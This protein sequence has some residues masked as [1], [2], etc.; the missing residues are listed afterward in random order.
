MSVLTTIEADLGKVGHAF[1]TGASKLK[2]VIIATAGVVDKNESEIATIEG[3]AN[4]VVAQIYPGAELVAIAIE[5]TM[6]K[7]F[8]AIDKAAAAAGADGMNVQLDSA[9]VAA[10]KAAL[11]TVKAQAS[12]TPG[13]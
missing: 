12:T 8:D 4:Q 6:A 13:A 10:I 9:T 5:G 7:V 2:A 1:V 3:V 11:P